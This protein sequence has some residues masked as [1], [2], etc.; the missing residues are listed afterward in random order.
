MAK[1]RNKVVDM[2]MY[3][4][5]RT[6][7]GLLHALPLETLYRGAA[8]V[9]ELIFRFDH[10]H[11]KRA[12]GHL[13][14][15]Y[16]HW[17]ER[18]VERVARAS[19]RSLAWM[20]IEFL[21]ITRKIGPNTW[22]RHVRLGNISQALR[23]LVEHKTGVIFL[24]GHF[25]N[26]EVTGYTLAILG[27]KSVA[28]ARPLNNPY[29]NRWALGRREAGGMRI[30]DKKGA[31]MEVDSILAAGGAVGFI[32][33]QDA[34]RRGIFVDFFGRPAS[35]FKSI[36]LMAMRH[37]VPIIVGAARRLAPRFQF[38]IGAE[39]IISPHEWADEKDPMRW[40]T[41]E[42]TTALEEMVRRDPDQ[43]LWAHRRWK[44]RPKGQDDPADGIA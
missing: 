9:A 39:R 38:E 2:L 16:P 23:L 15:S 25:G 22:R 36:A 40:I 14:R 24:T 33:D 21:L 11:R 29:L 42:Y 41:Q 13:R 31:A 5:L 6:V 7:A 30:L 18:Q 19:M 12:L 35:T 26:W 10:K 27:F 20:G 44:H 43:Y 28:V 34:G 4:V 17:D 1:P 32:A 3:V 37:E 8:L